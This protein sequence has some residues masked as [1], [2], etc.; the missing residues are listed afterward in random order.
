MP[1]WTHKDVAIEIMEWGEFRISLEVLKISS[2]PSLKAAQDAIDSHLAN[3]AIEARAGISLRALD[4]DGNPV[5]I[6]GVRRGSGSLLST[7]AGTSPAYVDTPQ[8]RGLLAR[9]TALWKER[10]GISATLEP[11]RLDPDYTRYRQTSD[12]DYP[13]VIALLKADYAKALAA[14]KVLEVKP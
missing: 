7:P 10:A 9:R 12:A 14:A 13:A 11:T 3:L 5:T 2:Y 6:T 1:S 8:T 4:Q